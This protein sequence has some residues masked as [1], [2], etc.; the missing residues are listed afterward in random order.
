MRP[1]VLQSL[2]M[3]VH[4]NGPSADEIA[5]YCQR[6]REIGNVKLVQVYTI[7]RRPMTIVDGAPAWQFVTALS[8]GE[9][10]AITERV[11]RETGLA[12]ESFYGG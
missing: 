2:F 10:D 1:V 8:D 4:G 7:A 9:V 3:N 11:R 6:L 12:A 5:A